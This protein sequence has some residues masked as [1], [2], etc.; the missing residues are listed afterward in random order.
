MGRRSVHGGEKLALIVGGDDFRIQSE[1]SVE[2][3]DAC[4]VRLPVMV[5]DW[6]CVIPGGGPSPFG[7]SDDCPAGSG[8]VRPAGGRDRHRQYPTIGHLE[9][10]RLVSCQ[11]GEILITDVAFLGPELRVR[12]R[13]F[14]KWRCPAVRSGRDFRQYGLQA[15]SALQLLDARGG[16]LGIIRARVSSEARRPW[17]PGLCREGASN[18]VNSGSAGVG[19]VGDAFVG[20]HLPPSSRSRLS[21]S[22][23]DLFES[24]YAYRQEEELPQRKAP[25]V[26][27]LESRSAS[28]S[29]DSAG[30]LRCSRLGQLLQASGAGVP[31][32]CDEVQLLRF[33]RLP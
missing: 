27:C 30:D 13:R 29:S 21:V 31:S 32:A 26:G 23:A 33:L 11:A 16:E 20:D 28:A 10:G 9:A 3:Q 12:S 4:S 7:E 15:A 24:R 19:Q 5:S 2:A 14:A 6:S 22:F 8:G 1:G 25:Q 17:W 18:R